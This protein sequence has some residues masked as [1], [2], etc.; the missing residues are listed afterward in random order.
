MTPVHESSLRNLGNSTEGGA[1]WGV[2]G[3]PHDVTFREGERGVKGDGHVGEGQGGGA[4][5]DGAHVL[6]E[7]CLSHRG[8]KVSHQ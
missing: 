6:Q 7:R 8:V 1:Q 5:R 2:T 4:G 3:G